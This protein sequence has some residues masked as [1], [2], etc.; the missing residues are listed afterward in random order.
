MKNKHRDVHF[1][2]YMIPLGAFVLFF[3]AIIIVAI[4]FS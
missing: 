2:Q 4:A 3:A 1:W